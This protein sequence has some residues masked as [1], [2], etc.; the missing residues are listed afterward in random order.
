MMIEDT[1]NTLFAKQYK[2]RILGARGQVH[3]TTTLA[4]GD[5]TYLHSM[6]NSKH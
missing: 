3:V 1:M 6:L 2:L 4:E 5:A